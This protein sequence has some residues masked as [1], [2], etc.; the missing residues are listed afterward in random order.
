MT[1]AKVLLISAV[2][3]T[4]LASSRSAY[5]QDA[6]YIQMLNTQLQTSV[7]GY[8]S[9]TKQMNDSL[10]RNGMPSAAA[11]GN[12]M[13]YLTQVLEALNQMDQIAINDPRYCP[14]ARQYQNYAVRGGVISVP[15]ASH[16][17]V[18]VYCARYGR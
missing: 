14:L 15:T 4:V 12:Q 11:A 16:A 7:Y 18:S 2:S 10:R 17:G 8:G 1:L 3:V 5:A 9:A 6:R 13:F